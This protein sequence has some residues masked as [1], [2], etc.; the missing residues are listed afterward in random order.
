MSKRNRWVM[1][2]FGLVLIVLVWKFAHEDIQDSHDPLDRE[3]VQRQ[4]PSK[5][6]RIQSPNAWAEQQR[7]ADVKPDHLEVAG[8]VVDA[9][10]GMGLGGATLT[11]HGGITALATSNTE[12]LWSI[13]LESPPNGIL[14]VSCEGYLSRDVDVEGFNPAN[15]EVRLWKACELRVV[16]IDE[17]EQAIRGCT[18]RLNCIAS[19]TIRRVKQTSAFGKSMFEDLPS[20]VEI[21]VTCQFLGQVKVQKITIPPNAGGATLAFQML[22]AGCSLSGQLLWTDGSPVTLP[23]RVVWFQRGGIRRAAQLDDE[24]RFQISQLPTGNGMV[25]IKTA[26]N[27]SHAVTLESGTNDLGVITLALMGKLAGSVT[28]L[29]APENVLVEALQSGRTIASA[30]VDEEGKFSLEVPTGDTV[31]AV[32]MNSSAYRTWMFSKNERCP[33]ENVILDVEGVLGTVTWTTSDSMQEAKITLFSHAMNNLGIPPGI[34]GRWRESKKV[35]P[36]GAGAWQV[37]SLAPG[38]YDVY[39]D[40]G[41]D[42]G[43]WA[44]DVKVLA[45]QTTDLNAITLGRGTLIWVGPDQSPSDSVVEPLMIKSVM[46]GSAFL[47]PGTAIDLLPGPWQ[48]E[49]EAAGAGLLTRPHLDIFVGQS[50]RF[51]WTPHHLGRIE[52]VAIG[53]S[54]PEANVS[55]E[56]WPLLTYRQNRSADS[57]EPDENGHF[58]FRRVLPGDYFLRVRTGESRFQ[59][60]VSVRAGEATQC[61]LDMPQGNS[62]ECLVLG[63]DGMPVSRMDRVYAISESGT[64]YRCRMNSSGTLYLV[65]GTEDLACLL[66]GEIRAT[67]QI[68][69]ET[70]QTYR[71]ARFRGH[72]KPALSAKIEPGHF[73]ISGHTGSKF[74]CYPVAISDAHVQAVGGFEFRLHVEYTAPGEATVHASPKRLEVYIREIKVDGSVVI[75]GRRPAGDM[76]LR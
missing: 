76:G 75:H 73:T 31:L 6:S 46:H 21:S 51:D 42:R 12:G 18:L 19:T 39:L 16:C 47:H 36:S 28:G 72:S 11:L 15:N 63:E 1:L 41:A 25:L 17:N 65:G 70:T 64:A 58:T 2:S 52:G 22:S 26:A 33:N 50:H 57:T 44:K 71:I 32:R 49:I 40:N 60:V 37:S 67:G 8:T 74:A 10:S 9:C 61:R 66:I 45:G 20:E 68:L 7:S 34:Q 53:L 38:T 5:P 56:L 13:E 30:E 24:G 27:I 69:A 43:F 23:G 35:E 62:A 48:V 29:N 59:Q 14:T 4:E 3:L 55:V 54:N